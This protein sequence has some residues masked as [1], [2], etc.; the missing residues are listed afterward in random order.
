MAAAA[1]GAAVVSELLPMPPER[2]DSAGSNNSVPTSAARKRRAAAAAVADTAEGDEDADEVASVAT[3]RRSGS[4]VSTSSA[5]P[6][7]KA[8]GNG[9][10]SKARRS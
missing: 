7:S 4:R 2:S 5:T 10:K 8:S 6:G 9:R 1:D 3:P